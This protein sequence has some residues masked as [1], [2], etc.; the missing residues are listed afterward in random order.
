MVNPPEAEGEF[1]EEE[2]DVIVEN[3]DKILGWAEEEVVEVTEEEEKYIE[4]VYEWFRNWNDF[5]YTVY[6]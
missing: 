1:T 2:V 4:A 6:M 5:F 3:A